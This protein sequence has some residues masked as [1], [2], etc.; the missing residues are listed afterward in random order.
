MWQLIC[1]IELGERACQS[2]NQTPS[3]GKPIWNKFTRLD[4]LQISV[5]QFC[6]VKKNIPDIAIEFFLS[7]I[8]ISDI[9]K[10]IPPIGEMTSLLWFMSMGFLTAYSID[11]LTKAPMCEW[12]PTALC[13]VFVRGLGTINMNSYIM[14]CRL[15]IQARRR[16][17]RSEFQS[18]SALPHSSSHSRSPVTPRLPQPLL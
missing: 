8:V 6:L 10:D 15:C 13:D 14:N 5:I 2:F 1:F 11:F 7:T 12:S 4:V 3:H 18:C 17:R 16:E 9:H